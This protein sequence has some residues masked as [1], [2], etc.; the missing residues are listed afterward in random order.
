MDEEQDDPDGVEGAENRTLKNHNKETRMRTS[1]GVTYYKETR[2]RTSL[3][4]ASMV[5]TWTLRWGSWTL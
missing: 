2:M 5:W 4:M 3:S 1:L